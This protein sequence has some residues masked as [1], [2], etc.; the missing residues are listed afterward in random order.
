MQRASWDERDELL[1]VLPILLVRT[2]ELLALVFRPLA[3]ILAG[4]SPR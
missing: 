3:T 4:E 2:D 1:E